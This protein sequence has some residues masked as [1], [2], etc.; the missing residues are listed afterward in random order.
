MRLV[1]C[2]ADGALGDLIVL[3]ENFGS[4]VAT[5][6]SGQIAMQFH[7]LEC[8]GLLV[9]IRPVAHALDAATARMFGI[10][11]FGP[12]IK[13][14][15]TQTKRR[16]N[17]DFVGMK[18]RAVGTFGIAIIVETGI[19]RHAGFGNGADISWHQIGQCAGR[20]T[21]VEAIIFYG[22]DQ[23][24][25][26]NANIRQS[27]AT[28]RPTGVGTGEAGEQSSAQRPHQ[29]RVDT[30]WAQA[31]DFPRRQKNNGR[32][33]DHSPLRDRPQPRRRGMEN[34]DPKRR[35]IVRRNRVADAHRNR[36]ANQRQQNTQR[37]Q[38]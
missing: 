33:R 3:I 30:K 16:L 19:S 14:V 24:N 22:H 32:A 10:I 37:A 7:G 27:S 13:V 21:V 28:P 34:A 23:G 12:I 9:Q 4:D 6:A 31:R 15:K 11:V 26:A 18:S 1:R 20:R 29:K 5:M 8:D 17:A 25:R 35:D 36:A 38:K 2:S